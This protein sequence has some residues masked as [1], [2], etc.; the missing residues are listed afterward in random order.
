MKKRLPRSLVN[1]K[2]FIIS[3][4]CV[5]LF[6]SFSYPGFLDV[7]WGGSCE[8]SRKFFG[9]T[10]GD[11]GV[12]F[13]AFETLW[14]VAIVCSEQGG[15]S[16]VTLTKTPEGKDADTELIEASGRINLQFSQKYGKP[17]TAFG[18]TYFRAS[19]TT[20]DAQVHM[21]V[22]ASAIELKCLRKA[23]PT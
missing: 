8:N 20:E 18:F 21:E 13:Q 3:V 19:W 14:S 11:T 17:Q 7:E 10:E 2:T 23:N 1:T 5:F 15:L 6:P 12:D 16:A 4:V 22:S 9:I